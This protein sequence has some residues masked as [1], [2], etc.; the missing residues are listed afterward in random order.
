[1]VAHRFHPYEDDPI[2]ALLYDRCDRCAE[3]AA[4]PLFL[5][6]TKLRAAWDRTV[7][8]ERHDGHYRTVNERKLCTNLYLMAVTIA[9]LQG[10]NDPWR[11]GPIRAVEDE[12]FVLPWN[13]EPT[14]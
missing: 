14:A 6:Q 2:G 5:D 9:R 1:M 4:S 10:H 11:V 12:D 7:Q 13:E 3:Q 8:V